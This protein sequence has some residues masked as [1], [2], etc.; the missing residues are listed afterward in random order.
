MELVRIRPVLR[1]AITVEALRSRSQE[2]QCD[3]DLLDR[4]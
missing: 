4:Q 2:R 3:S 1:N